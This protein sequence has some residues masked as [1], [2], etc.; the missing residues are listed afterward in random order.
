MSKA[1]LHPAVKD[2]YRIMKIEDWNVFC[3][4]RIRNEELDK[5]I[6]AWVQDVEFT[7]AVVSTEYLTS[8]Y[9]D[10]IKYKLTQSLAEDLAENC[11]T[12]KTEDKK[13][14][15]SMCAFRR[16]EKNKE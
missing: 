8:E 15:A 16:K 5:W 11:T 6:K 3:P 12:F 14:S 10:I 13:I 7:Q 4:E 1:K 9:N 2:L